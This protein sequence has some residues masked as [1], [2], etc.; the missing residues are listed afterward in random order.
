[1]N[2]NSSI[3]TVLAPENK[4]EKRVHFVSRKPVILCVDDE[5]AF[6]ETLERHI[7]RRFGGDFNVETADS[8]E[9][10]LEVLENLAAEGVAVALIVSDQLMPGMLGDE[11]LTHAMKYAPETPKILLTGQADMESVV[12]AIN[13]ARLFRYIS[14]P[15]D[16][17][18]LTR[19]LHEALQIYRQKILLDRY[20]GLFH[21]LNFATQR[22]SAQLDK[23]VICSILAESTAQICGA[24]RVEVV[25][26]DCTVCEHFNREYLRQTQPDK[27]PANVLDVPMYHG[28]RRLGRLIVEKEHGFD[29]VDLEALEILASQTAIS[30]V[31]AELYQDLAATAHELDRHRQILEKYN[32][33]V[34]DSI[35]YARRIQYAILPERETLDRLLPE[36]FV[37]Y[38]PKDI[39]SGDFYFWRE[40]EGILTLAVCDCTGHG[41]PGAFVSLIASE[42]LNRCVVDCHDPAEILDCTEVM[43]K[44]RLK[45]RLDTVDL[46]LVRLDLYRQTMGFAGARRPLWLVRNGEIQSLRG[47]R[48][49]L[50]EATPVSYESRETS[51]LPG[52]TV[53]LFTDGVVD[54]FGGENNR[55][56]NPRRLQ[57]LILRI[58]TLPLCEQER[59]IRNEI[60]TWR[61]DNEYTDDLL[62]V[63]FRY[64][65]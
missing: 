52:D 44:R 9:E 43:F 11:F 3:A 25:R 54:Q 51:L 65:G 7:L 45:D 32:R 19:N 42:C 6:L 38:Q 35:V 36:N 14:K 27:I 56:F 63:G 24:T 17:E 60:E 37:L 16:E 2:D 34:T 29:Q 40:T 55:K 61:R 31:N 41:V 1:M 47:T 26:D 4:L 39:V 20:A 8:G 22:I 53:Y 21:S 59:T 28:E 13:R 48:K 46:A 15:W 18:E 64:E 30:M 10:A 57:E 12:H 49:S 62:V 58:H 23:C 5:K 33:D 50:G